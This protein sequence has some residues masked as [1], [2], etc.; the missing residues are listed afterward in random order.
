MFCNWLFAPRKSCAMPA[1]EAAWPDWIKSPNGSTLS[2]CAKCHIAAENAETPTPAAADA[3][4][5]QFLFKNAITAFSFLSLPKNRAGTNGAYV[6]AATRIFSLLVAWAKSYI[7]FKRCFLSKASLLFKVSSILLTSILYS[8]LTSYFALTRF[9]FTTVRV[10]SLGSFGLFQFQNASWVFSKKFAFFG[11]I[12]KT[13]FAESSLPK[14]APATPADNPLG[15]GFS[16]IRTP[17]AWS[18]NNNNVEFSIYFLGLTILSFVA[19]SIFQS[20]TFRKFLQYSENF[21]KNTQIYEFFCK[22]G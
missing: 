13:S 1:C 22:K 14:I 6:C 20:L 7:S 5:G 12:L 3:I 17:C 21:K 4:I 9:C 18:A 19:H 10:A 15:S 8:A 11:V 16:F 2:G